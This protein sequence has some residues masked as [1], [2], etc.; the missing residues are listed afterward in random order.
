MTAFS[1]LVAHLAST[2]RQGFSGL[3]PLCSILWPEKYSNAV[4]RCPS[5]ATRSEPLT[6][7]G[8]RR[9]FLPLK[10]PGGM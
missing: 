5:K 4:D 7:T 2:E 8:L 1:A 9:G 10:F 6:D 3:I